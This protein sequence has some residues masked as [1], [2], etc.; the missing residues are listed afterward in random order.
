MT[1][2]MSGAR[3]LSLLAMSAA[4]LLAGCAQP[5]AS[6]HGTS[7][8][9]PALSLGERPTVVALI[10]TGINPY[11][12]DFILPGDE[13]AE[14]LTRADVNATMVELSSMGDWQ[15]RKSADDH[16]WQTA[17]DGVLYRFAG[18]RIFAISFGRDPGTLPILDQYASGQGHG[19][20]TADMVARQD[21]DAIILM[22]QAD[23][24]LCPTQANPSCLLD[25]SVA[26]A[27]AW[28]ANQPWIDIIS[29][30]LNVPGNPPDS[31]EVHP[32][33]AAYLAASRAASQNGKLIVASAGNEIGPTIPSFF[34][35]PPWVIAVGGGQPKRS[36]EEITASKAVDVVANYTE[37]VADGN[38]IDGHH[39][40]DG[41]S[42]SAPN[43]AGVLSRALHDIRA[44]VHDSAGPTDS[45]TIASGTLAD[46]SIL[47]VNSGQLREAL[48]AS[49]VYWNATDWD[50]L[51]PVSNDT[52]FNLGEQTAPVLFAPAQV[53]W[54]YV[55]GTIVPALVQHV[56]S[57]DP[58]Y[59]ADKMGAALY[60][61]QFQNAREQYWAEMSS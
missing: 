45:S 37:S 40:N 21:P 10:D 18:T 25:S 5:S 31:R 30:S 42:F 41:T 39:W 55:N 59:S 2:L 43:V 7:A 36:G 16:F 54:G 46:G 34:A 24:T 29:V 27:M 23:T 38:T 47:K 61:G 56:L 44:R 6:L 11:H 53:G 17:R 32:E 15:E 8:S 19:T 13:A 12:R 3:S 48:N 4:L 35:G 33:A 28:A 26:R 50:D 60:Q 51:A 9:K 1:V 49:A 58:T 52:V 22:I 57:D 20:G 14:A